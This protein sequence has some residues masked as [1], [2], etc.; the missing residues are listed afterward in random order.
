MPF[1]SVKRPWLRK[2]S[3]NVDIDWSHPLAKGLVSCVILNGQQPIDLVDNS[4]GTRVGGVA[5]NKYDKDGLLYTFD[6]VNDYINFGDK[7]RYSVANGKMSAFARASNL[8]TGQQQP[9]ITKYDNVLSSFAGEYTLGLEST[10]ELAFQV[11][12][13]AYNVKCRM[14][15][16]SPV[17]LSGS[18]GASWD[19][20]GVDEGVTLYMDGQSVAATGGG[21]DTSFVSAENTA[22]DFVI[23]AGAIDE[24]AYDEYLKGDISIALV[25][26]RELS[27][28]EHKAI[29]E[30]PYQLLKPKT[31]YF[32][33]GDGVT[34]VINST[35]GNVTPSISGKVNVS[36][37]LVQ[38]L[39]G[40]SLDG[41]GSVEAVTGALAV[42]LDNVVLSGNGEI[43]V[44]GLANVTLADTT[45]T[46]VG[47]VDAIVGT[48]NSSLDSVGITASGVVK[49]SGTINSTL[50]D[51]TISAG[52]LDSSLSPAMRWWHSIT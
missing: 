34:G 14:Q 30:N 12:D 46:G 24:P 19:N 45:L 39:A 9:F 13:G 51:I 15:S 29:A 43:K 52:N 6:G 21:E 38:T 26:D 33:I 16:N 37:T 27:A 28:T 2:P 18:Y 48:L 40:A 7:D 50:E 8:I 23:G 17:A 10:N 32:S 41:V 47:E 44:T 35:L 4:F 1:F 20:S 22:A 49:V 36:G 31:V 5:S 25:W 3:Y 42:N 11:L